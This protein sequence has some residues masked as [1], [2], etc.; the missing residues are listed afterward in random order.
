MG[1]TPTDGDRLFLYPPHESESSNEFPR[2]VR[3]ISYGIQVVPGESGS[4]YVGGSAVGLVHVFRAMDG[5]EIESLGHSDFGLVRCV[6][7]SFSCYQLSM[8]RC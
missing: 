7:V 8:M 3:L 2:A 1:S 4:I 5:Q 6:A